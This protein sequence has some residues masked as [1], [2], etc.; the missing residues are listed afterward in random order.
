MPNNKIA[1]E[2]QTYI[3]R[4]FIGPCYK[5]KRQFFIL[6]FTLL[7]KNIERIDIDQCQTIFDVLIMKTDFEYC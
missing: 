6:I 7:E 5:Q 1:V 4:P 2:L 3:E